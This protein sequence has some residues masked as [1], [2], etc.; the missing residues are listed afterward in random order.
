MKTPSPAAVPAR[1]ALVVIGSATAAAARARPDHAALL[2]ALPGAARVLHIGPDDPVLA[3]AYRAM[4]AGCIWHGADDA[5]GDHDLVVLS[6]GWL[7]QGDPATLLQAL[8]ERCAPNGQL[9][10]EIDNQAQFAMLQR[11]VEADLTDADDGPLAQAQLRHA[12]PASFYKLLLDTGWSPT[13]AG[14]TAAPPVNPALAAAAVAL[15]ESVG[16]PAATARRQLGTG[17]LI[18]QA[19]RCFEPCSAAPEPARFS[20]VVPTTR[21]TQLRL[22]VEHSPGLREV[23]ARIVSYRR[24]RSPAEALEASLQHVTTDWV[25]LCHQDVYFPAGFGQRLNELLAGI[26]PEDAPRTLIGFA[27]M[28]VDAQKQGYEPAGF[29]IDRRHRFDHPASETAVSIDELAIVIARDSVHHIDP[30]L[31]W[32]LWATDLCIEAIC[33]HKVFPRIVRLPLFHN[34]SNDHQLPAAF[35]ASAARLAAKHPGFGPIA[36]LCGTID[37]RFLQQHRSQAA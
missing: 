3:A 17:R 15:A 9:F 18:V 20:V 31:G 11:W 6:A 26:A 30:A 8:H 34:S 10:V 27:G 22:N 37:E 13:L 28:G 2:K 21:E 36:T 29:V 16:V 32:H 14:E 23:D 12:S 19:Q 7:G 1:P 5:S 33:T 24:A 4:H 35:H 25:L